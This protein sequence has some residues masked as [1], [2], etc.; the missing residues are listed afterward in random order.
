MLVLFLSY[1]I[2]RF[3]FNVYVKNDNDHFP[4]W[5]GEQMLK[6]STDA[7]YARKI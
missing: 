6:M 1:I 3:V 5:M 4:E 2:E 7:I